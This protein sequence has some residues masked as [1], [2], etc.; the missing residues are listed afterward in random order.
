MAFTILFQILKNWWWFFFPLILVLPFKFFYFWWITWEVWDKKRKYTFLELIPP[1]EV[2]KPFKAMEDVFN[3]LWTIFY[4]SPNWKERWCEGVPTKFVS[5]FS[6][7]IVS[8]K[9]EIHFYMRIEK[10]FVDEVKATF[11][12]HYP[13]MEIKEVEDYTKEVPRDIPNEK[14]DLYSE[15]FT[16]LKDEVYPIKTYS[17]FFE[18]PEQ[19]ARI[20][21][22]KRVDPLTSLLEAL[23][24]LKSGERYW[25][26]ICVTPIT[27][28]EVPI[29]SRGRAIADKIAKRP[30]SPPKR[31][32]LHE[33]F[34]TLIDALIPGP[35]RRSS[36]KK[37]TLLVGPE[38]LLTPG[39]KEIL[40]AIE[41]KISKP[42]FNCFIRI[43]YLY[44]KDEPYS[45]INFRIARNY[46]QHFIH[47]TLNGIIFFGPTRTKIHYWLR[48]RR[49]YLRKRKNLRNYIE[50][51]PPYSPW[52]SRGIPVHPIDFGFYPK[53]PGKW[54]KGTFVLSSEEL[55]SIFHFPAKITVPTMP[56]VITKKVGPPPILP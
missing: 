32:F 19:E 7:E 13:E 2:K 21:Q 36:S 51:I 33:I 9:G 25:M 55:T 4:N 1:E 22:E 5:W 27:D 53:T 34:S 49:L 40:K 44:K 41:T 18:R 15:E 50:R 3:V 47:T 54:Q 45:R 48:E 24:A 43:V 23:S 37:E 29:H 11:Y 52:N 28:K 46:F 56:R 42:C 10:K 12:S 30:S 16:L 38:I 8:I 14:W 6:L 39:E 31:F 17:M 20:E 35:P 26:Q